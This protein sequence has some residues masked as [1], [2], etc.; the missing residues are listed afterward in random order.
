MSGVQLVSHVVR[1]RLGYVLQS[2]AIKKKKVQEEGTQQGV[3]CKSRAM[4]KRRLSEQLI[5]HKCVEMGRGFKKKTA[6]KESKWG[7]RGR[8]RSRTRVAGKLSGVDE[9]ET[10]RL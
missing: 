10:A 7:S 1:G 5:C 8:R 4:V 6:S 9:E 3:A 2:A